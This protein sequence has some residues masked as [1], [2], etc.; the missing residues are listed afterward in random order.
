[1]SHRQWPS[2]TGLGAPSCTRPGN[3]NPPLRASPMFRPFPEGHWSHRPTRAL[4]LATVLLLAA[5][6]RPATPQLLVDE[7]HRRNAA[8]TQPAPVLAYVSTSSNLHR[9]RLTDGGTSHSSTDYQIPVPDL[10]VADYIIAAARRNNRPIPG[11]IRRFDRTYVFMAS[12]STSVRIT[13]PAPP[14]A[15]ATPDL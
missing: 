15:A 2:D 12:A 1:M 7:L 11:T 10:Q 3:S 6:A 13:P 9:L 5:C 4:M 14:A 8:A